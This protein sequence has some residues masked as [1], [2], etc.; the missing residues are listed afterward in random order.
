MPNDDLSGLLDELEAKNGKRIC[1]CSSCDCG[2]SGNTYSVG[3][4]D[5]ADWILQEIRK[6]IASKEDISMPFSGSME[7]KQ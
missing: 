2:N 3:S 7:H 5:G 1:D 4:W 6:A